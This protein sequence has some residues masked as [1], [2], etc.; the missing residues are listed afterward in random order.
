MEFFYDSHGMTWECFLAIVGGG[1][2]AFWLVGAI[3]EDCLDKKGG[4]K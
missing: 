3:I 4:K 1:H 2:I